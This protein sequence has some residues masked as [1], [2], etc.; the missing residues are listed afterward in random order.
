MLFKPQ[1]HQLGNG[2]HATVNNI[3][4]ITELCDNLMEHYMYDVFTTPETS[5]F[6]CFAHACV[7]VDN[8]PKFS[9][10]IHILPWLSASWKSR[11]KKLL[12]PQHS[13]A[14]G[15]IPGELL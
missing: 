4:Q 3:P 15:F 14:S 13:R 10:V 8:A 12:G 7:W 2:D 6:L 1:F 11:T 5:L 9:D